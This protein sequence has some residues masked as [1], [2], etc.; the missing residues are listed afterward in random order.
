MKV[1]GDIVG[2]AGGRGIINLFDSYLGD[3]KKYLARRGGGGGGVEGS[4]K[5]G[6]SN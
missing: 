3:R 5:S 1:A 6:G 4:L 2:E